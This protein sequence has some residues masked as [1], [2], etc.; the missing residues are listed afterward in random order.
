MWALMRLIFFTPYANNIVMSNT[1]MA[2]AKAKVKGNIQLHTVDCEIVN[3]IKIPKYKT[4]VYGQNAK[5]PSNPIKN[6]PICV[7][8]GIILNT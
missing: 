5:D 2:V 4:P 3:G 8:L 7:F 1:G 6:A